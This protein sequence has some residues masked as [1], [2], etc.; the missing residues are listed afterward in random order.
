[1][2]LPT[3][4]HKET[5]GRRKDV[6]GLWQL[7]RALIGSNHGNLNGSHAPLLGK[8]PVVAFFGGFL[9]IKG[10]AIFTAIKVT[11][12]GDAEFNRKKIGPDGEVRSVHLY[13]KGVF[14]FL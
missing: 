7:F 1:V 3:M 2:L 8:D 4:A 13:G 9:D 12:I 11:D 5:C 6:H 10:K 14:P